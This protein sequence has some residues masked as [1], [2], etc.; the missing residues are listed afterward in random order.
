M[1]PFNQHH[2][3]VV[4]GGMIVA[5]SVCLAL[6]NRIMPYFFTLFMA[7]PLA[8][9]AI[10]MKP[11]A[12]LTAAIA[13]T[14]LCGMLL[15]PLYAV[16][17]FCSYAMLGVYTGWASKKGVAFGKM[18]LVA[19]LLQVLGMFIMFGVQLAIMGFDVPKF[20]Q[21]VFGSSDELYDFA[22]A[23]AL[24]D[25]LQ[26]STTMSTQ[27]LDHMLWQISHTMFMLIPSLYLLTILVSVLFHVS[28]LWLLCKRLSIAVS[29][30][31]PPIDRMQM[32][33]WLLVPTLSAWG[34]VLLNRYVHIEWLWAIAIN[35]LCLS[36]VT[37]AAGGYS[38]FA[39]KSRLYHM[40]PFKRLLIMLVLLF[41]FQYSLPIL[42]LVGIFD[43]IL[44]YRHLR[45]TDDLIE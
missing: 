32:P 26:S 24:Y 21:T 10:M 31:L 40:R 17:F 33:V 28:F 41:F 19:S 12:A 39:A 15:G 23:S 29:M 6:I 5:L 37:F 2:S 7:L 14:L 1:K 34:L 42:A 25:Y 13:A 11:K 43:T 45:Q 3:P 35:L 9:G 30:Q 16:T 36:A 8:L 22:K 18:V 4:M 20:V 38:F 44:D 27:A